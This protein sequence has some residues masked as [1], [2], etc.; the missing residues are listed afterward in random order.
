MYRSVE[1]FV[2]PTFP[3]SRNYHKQRYTTPWDTKRPKRLSVHVSSSSSVKRRGGKGT[4]MTHFPTYRRGK[5]SRR[6]PGGVPWQRNVPSPTLLCPGL[7][8]TRDDW[9]LTDVG[10]TTRREL[11]SSPTLNGEGGR[12]LRRSVVTR[13]KDGRGVTQ[14]SENRPFFPFLQPRTPPTFNL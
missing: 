1:S 13:S 3:R 2:G 5:G 4:P 7:L 10:D 8:G 9:P 6:G 12:Y 11:Q 14:D